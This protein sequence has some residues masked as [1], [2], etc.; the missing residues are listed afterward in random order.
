MPLKSSDGV[1]PTDLTTGSA[2]THGELH[3]VKLDSSELPTENAVLILLSTVA[4]HQ[5]LLPISLF[6]FDTVTSSYQQLYKLSI[7]T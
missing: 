2:L 1:F 7:H 6:E 3:G 4:H 5:Y